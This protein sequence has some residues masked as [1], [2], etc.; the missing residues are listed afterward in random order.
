[1]HVTAT[2]VAGSL[3]VIVPQGVSVHVDGRTGA[4]AMNLLGLYDDGLQV[5]RLAGSSRDRAV[6][7]LDLAVSFGRIVVFRSQ[8]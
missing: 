3:E 2:E 8:T 4:G 5:H 1:V 6:I 7:D